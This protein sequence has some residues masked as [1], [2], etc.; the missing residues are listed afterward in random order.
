MFCL[1]DSCFFFCLSDSNKPKKI[2]NCL[3]F[4]FVLKWFVHVAFFVL[5]FI[6]LHLKKVWKLFREFKKHCLMLVLFNEGYIYYFL[7][8][9]KKNG[10]LEDANWKRFA[11]IKTRETLFQLITKLLELQLLNKPEIN[12]VFHVTNIILI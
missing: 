12:R 1:M 9:K 11:N 4:M 6:S 7:K 10:R 2:N 3:L 5:L 8:N